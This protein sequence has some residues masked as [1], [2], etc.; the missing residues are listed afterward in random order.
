M[1]AQVF[2]LPTFLLA[3]LLPL[4]LLHA[5]REYWRLRQLPQIHYG[6]FSGELMQVGST[7]IAKRPARNN[8]TRT[9]I[10]FPGFLEDMRYFQELYKDTEAEL[11]LIN[12][13]NYHCPFATDL[14]GNKVT[15]LDWPQNPYKLG[16]IEHDGFYIG[17]ALDKLA[18]GDNIIVHGHSR[19]GAVVLEA[20]RQ[21]SELIQSTARPV[22]AIL[23]AAVLPQ[24]RTIGNGSDRLP[25][26]IQCYFMPIFF[27]LMRNI[28]EERVLKMPMMRPT[29]P[30]KNN[31]CQSIFSTS[32][33][34]NTCI[35]NVRSIYT[36]QR[37]TGF[38]VY[39]NYPA[40]TVL[41]GERDSVLDN[42]SMLASAEQGQAR[43]SGLSIFRTKDT[44][45]LISLEQPD[46]IRAI[47]QLN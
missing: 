24:A 20:G 19:G 46:S 38:E 43:N 47:H 16:T 5:Y 12:N 28:S 41:L 10:C 11:I 17:L 34:Y 39:N 18:T 1:K 30:L 15:Q 2:I 37:T 44:N 33:C 23:E 36:W 4:L 25:H 21:Y 45:H 22:N 13:A 14:D 31:L 7:Y 3:L 35:A 32:G 26:T 27:G 42:K 40:I 6:E 9:I 29:N 8:N